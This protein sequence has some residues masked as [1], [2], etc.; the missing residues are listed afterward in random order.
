[1]TA[2]AKSGELTMSYKMVIGKAFMSQVK[3]KCIFCNRTVSVRFIY[4]VEQQAYKISLKSVDYHDITYHIQG[5]RNLLELAS[6]NIFL[7]IK[8]YNISFRALSFQVI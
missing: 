4:Q 6:A 5:F 7:Y 8:L 1:M 2:V 3:K